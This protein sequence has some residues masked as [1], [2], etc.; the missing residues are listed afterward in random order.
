M[1]RAGLQAD[2]RPKQVIPH[3][4]YERSSIPK[5][6]DKRLHKE[7]ETVE[8]GPEAVLPSIES[9]KASR[10]P[11]RRFSQSENQAIV[12]DSPP[13]EKPAYFPEARDR[14]DHVSLKRRRLES[15]IGRRKISENV[16]LGPIDAGFSASG[17]GPPAMIPSSKGNDRGKIVYLPLRDR[18]EEA[19]VSRSTN[20]SS[21]R[22]TFRDYERSRQHDLSP[23]LFNS[24]SATQRSREVLPEHESSRIRYYVNE[25]SAPT[26]VRLPPASGDHQQVFGSTSYGDVSRRQIYI[27]EQPRSGATVSQRRLETYDH[28]LSSQNKDSPRRR[29]P[30]LSS[31]ERLIHKEALPQQDLFFESL[32]PITQVELRN[33]LSEKAPEHRNRQ[34]YIYG[35]PHSTQPHEIP[36]RS[37]QRGDNTYYLSSHLPEHIPT[38]AQV[39]YVNR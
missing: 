5:R 25:A 12:I 24:A 11:D 3:P 16:I 7:P 31:G 28:V 15:P 10:Q 20:L 37:Q 17:T 2:S 18:G 29:Q 27:E 4:S 6:I 13:S 9:P 19:V 33:K 23:N 22:D 39:H 34:Q 21:A 14:Q 32:E 1:Q 35:T 26:T 30:L 8:R 38:E 36:S